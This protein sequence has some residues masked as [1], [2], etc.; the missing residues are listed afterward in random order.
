MLRN[1][2]FIKVAYYRIFFQNLPF[3]DELREF[4]KLLYF[5]TRFFWPWTLA[6]QPAYFD[7]YWHNLQEVESNLM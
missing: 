7:A 1:V 5:C 3:L 6:Y 2:S 4:S